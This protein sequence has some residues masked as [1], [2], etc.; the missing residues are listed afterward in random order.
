MRGLGL[1]VVAV[2][3]ISGCG[4]GGSEEPAP[5]AS[6]EGAAALTDVCSSSRDCTALC[7]AHGD[8]T[9]TTYLDIGYESGYKPCVTEASQKGMT[10]QQ[11]GCQERAHM[12]CMSA[13]SGL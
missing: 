9:D 8:V 6:T 13:C 11:L 2:F 1:L 3:G 12:A 10:A 7:D 4:G 5:G